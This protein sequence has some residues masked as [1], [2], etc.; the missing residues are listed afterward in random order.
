[1]ASFNSWNG[2]K[3]HGNR[4]LLTDVLKEQARLRRLRHL[5]L[6]WRGLSLGRPREALAM[7][8]NAGVDMFMVSVKWQ[9]YLELLLQ[10]A[11]SGVVPI[12]RIDDAVRRIL[13]VKH[14]YGLFD[15]PRPAERPWSR[16]SC[17]GAPEHRAVAREAV[18]K[19][20][21]LLQNDGNLLPLSRSA[22]IL[23]AGKNADNRG[24]QC[25]GFTVAWQGT[26]GN[27]SILAARRSGKA[28]VP[29]PRTRY[30]ARMDRWPM[31]RRT[32][33]RSW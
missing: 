3:C 19:S 1:M 31:R 6:G 7:A 18:R 9:Q 24:H 26:S 2:V 23:V 11:R 22:R 32:T 28:F 14:R 5:R 15:R 10:H 29:S 20:L 13:T 21:V 16:Q 8:A 25:G 4:Y 27:Q 30:S 17:L 33:L 12:S